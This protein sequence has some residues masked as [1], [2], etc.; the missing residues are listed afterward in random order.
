MTLSRSSLIFSTPL[1]D[2]AS[3]S[4]TSIK[5]PFLMAMQLAHSLRQ[6]VYGLGKY[7]CG[8]GLACASGA[9]QKIGV[10]YLV[11]CY[12]VLKYSYYM[13]LTEYLIEY[14]G[15]VCSVQCLIHKPS[16]LKKLPFE[17]SAVKEKAYLRHI[18]ASAYCCFLPDLTRFAESYCAGP[19]PIRRSFQK[20]IQI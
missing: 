6:T 1:F 20:A 8:C 3:I 19:R 18:R 14:L 7:S 12:L 16:F 10:A 17:S 4:I 5:V 15:S 9:A 11:L 13:L 2:A